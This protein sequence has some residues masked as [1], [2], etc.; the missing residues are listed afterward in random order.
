MPMAFD[1]PRCGQRSEPHTWET[2][3]LER[4][5]CPR[6]KAMVD[7]AELETELLLTDEPAP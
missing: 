3:D 7:V 4:R 1:C 2:I 5:Q 6:C